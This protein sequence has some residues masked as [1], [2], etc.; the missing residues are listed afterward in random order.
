MTGP[1]N[2]TNVLTRALICPFLDLYPTYQPT[3]G[4]QVLQKAWDLL[5]DCRQVR[6]SALYKQV[7]KAKLSPT[8]RAAHPA[9]PCLYHLR[10]GRLYGGR[11]VFGVYVWLGG[12]APR[13]RSRPERASDMHPQAP[14][15]Q[16][17]LP[18]CL[19]PT[20]CVYNGLDCFDP[21]LAIARNVR[22]P[23]HVSSVVS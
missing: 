13:L 9:A 6:Q 16:T 1:Q 15:T 3:G 20:A 22:E 17:F 8:P 5:S 10:A 7:V 23:L 11:W 19:L 12:H 18:A 4:V 14:K 2:K 21:L